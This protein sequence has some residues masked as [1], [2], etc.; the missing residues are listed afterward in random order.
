MTT[1]INAKY[2]KIG[3]ILNKAGPYIISDN[4][5]EILKYAIPEDYL[6]FLL[7]FK[8]NISQT[9]EQLKESVAKY[10]E[11]SY[12]EEEIL[13]MVDHLAKHGVM[14][15]QPNRHGV[16][17]FRLAPIYRQFEYTFMK[18]LEKTDEMVGLAKLFHETEK[19]LRALALDDYD[20]LSNMVK[21]MPAMDRT[22][23]I[24]ENKETGEEIKIILDKDLE[25]PKEE[26][27]SAQDIRE[28]VNK[29][30]DIA[31]G[32]CYCRQKEDFLGH[33]CQQNPPGESCFTLGKS[34]RHTAKH[35][36]T[37]L[38]SKEEALSILKDIEDAGLVHKVYHL[39]SDLSK[40]EVAICNCCSC[41]CPT[42]KGAV[43][44]P[45]V[46]I[47][48]YTVDI[49]QDLCVGCGTCIEKC[50]N[51]VLELNDQGLAERV[52]EE[53]VGCGV[54]AYLC[55]ENAASLIEGPYRRVNILPERENA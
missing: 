12:T 27:V 26:V 10:C 11:K 44:F 34:A 33:K 46:N 7:A 36:F 45:M 41:C 55:P 20:N 6:D 24:R 16:V 17:V 31:V 42:S 21:T 54:C 13:K 4:V 28:I 1:H 32:Q 52:G 29:F 53:C 14:F 37:R 30:D 8:R 47:A 22:V 5:I 2:K 49:D 38:I 35:G 19:E 40:D 3:D 18:K 23:P 50:F 48:K 15:D 39:N 9:M 25:I 51:R 43:M